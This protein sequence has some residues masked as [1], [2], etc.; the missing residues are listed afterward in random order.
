MLFWN[1]V[2]GID[3]CFGKIGYPFLVFRLDVQILFVI[4]D[5]RR[6]FMLRVVIVDETPLPKLYASLHVVFLYRRTRD[7]PV[8]LY[9]NALF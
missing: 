2:I 8:P 1:A 7:V 4:V 3:Y 5:V 6:V 9:Q